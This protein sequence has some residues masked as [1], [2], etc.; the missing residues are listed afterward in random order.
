VKKL[1][2]NHTLSL[3]L[4]IIVL[5]AVSVFA[6]EQ[7]QI[8]FQNNLKDIQEK[9][10][11]LSKSNEEIL[12]FI[13]NMEN[14]FKLYDDKFSLIEKEIIDIKEKFNNINQEIFKLDANNKLALDK[15]EDFRLKFDMI[16]DDIKIKAD[17]IKSIRE[18]ISV[19][20]RNLETNIENTVECKKSLMELSSQKSN[21]EQTIVEDVL[22]WEYWGVVA[23][24]IAVIALILAITK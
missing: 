4:S 19:L 17:D 2:F 23:S 12:K 1:R 8:D 21:K 3:A 9:I 14:S 6:E 11:S 20:K 22:K 7:P 18:S 16:N 15:L 24:G 13:K 10:D 5:L